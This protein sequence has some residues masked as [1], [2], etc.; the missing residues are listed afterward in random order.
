MLH[1]RH[2]GET[3]Q[4][5]RRRLIREQIEM[6]TYQLEELQEAEAEDL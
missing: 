1:R 6:L 5:R 3:L 2:R 4:E